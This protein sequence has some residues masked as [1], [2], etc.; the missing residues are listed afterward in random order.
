MG[1]FLESTPR[2]S[3]F[4]QYVKEDVNLMRKIFLVGERNRFSAAWQ[5]SP[6]IRRVSYKGLGEG[7]TLCT[8]GRGD[9]TALK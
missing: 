4:D 8:L 7:E 5:D 2:G 3:I 9:K 1:S 6:L